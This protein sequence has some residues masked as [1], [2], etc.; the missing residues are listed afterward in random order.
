MLILI[1]W[2]LLMI[3]SLP[4]SSGERE[5]SPIDTVQHMNWKETLGSSHKTSAP[6][7]YAPTH[8]PTRSP[9]FA[10]TFETLQLKT[11]LTINKFDSPQNISSVVMKSLQETIEVVL[12]GKI[13]IQTMNIVDQIPTSY[14]VANQWNVVI[15]TLLTFSSNTFAKVLGS[16]ENTTVINYV[17]KMLSQSASTRQFNGLLHLRG[18][19]IQSNEIQ[20]I[21]V[22]SIEFN[23]YTSVQQSQSASAAVASNPASGDGELLGMS[24]NTIILIAIGIALGAF[25]IGYFAYEY[26]SMKRFGIENGGGGLRI[27]ECLCWIISG[28]GL[29]IYVF[30]QYCISKRKPIVGNGGEGIGIDDSV[31]EGREEHDVDYL[32]NEPVDLMDFYQMNSSND[33][34]NSID[35]HDEENSINSSSQRSVENTSGRWDKKSY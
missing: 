6:P 29:T 33:L 26:I 15:E 21:S 9:T 4:V 11:F 17:E 24:G 19:E 2:L 27:G 31:M 20:N 1:I 7:T 32:L 25:V 8:K 23:G 28:L 34:M 30:F 22:A 18:M 5:Y 10:P 13:N 35:E 14:D 16:H 3:F 12:L